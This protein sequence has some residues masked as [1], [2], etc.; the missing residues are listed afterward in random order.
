[1]QGTDRRKGARLEIE[2]YSD[3][4]QVDVVPAGSLRFERLQRRSHVEITI[5]CGAQVQTLGDAVIEAETEDRPRLP[6]CLVKLRAPDKER[7]AGIG[8]ATVIV[9]ANERC[10]LYRRLRPEPRNGSVREDSEIGAQRKIAGHADARAGDLCSVF[11]VVEGAAGER[12]GPG[13][14]KIAERPV[15]GCHLA[16]V[17]TVDF[18]GEIRIQAPPREYATAGCPRNTCANFRGGNHVPGMNARHLLREI[19]IQVYTS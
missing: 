6:C 12:P 9:D 1:M 10:Q 7:L 19:R 4:D 5:P 13:A 8:Y 2:G 14:W 15:S 11:E 3:S 18:K 16:E 17:S